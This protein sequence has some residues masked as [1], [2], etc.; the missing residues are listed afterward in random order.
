MESNAD[1]I[2]VHIKESGHQ[3]SHEFYGEL[4]LATSG[5][6]HFDRKPMQV[7]ALLIRTRTNIILHKLERDLY[8]TV[9]EIIPEDVYFHKYDR[10][11]I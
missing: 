10:G 11:D 4:L 7:A 3:Y 9:V 8:Q 6:E 1:K 2:F 5:V